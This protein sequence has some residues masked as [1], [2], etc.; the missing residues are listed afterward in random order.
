MS[1]LPS[2]PAR[3][4]VDDRL[5]QLAGTYGLDEVAVRGL[6]SLLSIL[7][8]EERAPTSVREP[9]AAVDRHV[10][11][12]LV[13]LEIAAVHGARAVADLGA[14][15]GVPG[16][17]L[18][19]AVPQADVALVESVG[20]KCAFMD[21]AIA[22]MG[23]GNARTVPLR[24][25]EWREGLGTRDLVTARA[26]APLSVLLEYAAPL[27]RPEGSFLAWKGARDAGEEADAAAAAADLG[28]EPV[29]VRSV[30]PFAGAEHRH[31][32]LY[33]KVRSTPNRYPRRAGMARKRPIQ[34]SARA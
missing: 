10:A 3:S 16:L 33:L 7:S 14:G 28:L 20:R 19:A 5:G 17:V 11:D 6:R 31:L 22:A 27:L 13:A 8:E 32:H 34:A 18:A 4:R 23:L 30:Q 9:A 12:T 15:A 26:V 21:R 1:G 29:E 2:Q 25:E 24:A